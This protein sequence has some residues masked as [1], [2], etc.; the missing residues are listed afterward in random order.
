MPIQLFFGQLQ[1]FPGA[2][3]FHTEL[4][5]GRKKQ[6]SH[7]EHPGAK[8]SQNRFIDGCRFTGGAEVMQH[9]FFAAVLQKERQR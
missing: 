4:Y 3:E 8:C 7:D 9:G 1:G 5:P 2:P 6:Q